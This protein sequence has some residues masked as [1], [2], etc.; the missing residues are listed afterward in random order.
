MPQPSDRRRLAD[1]RAL[2]KQGLLQDTDDDGTLLCTMSGPEAT[3][4]EGTTL[5]VRIQLPVDYPFRSPSVGFV[6]QVYH[7]NVDMSSGSICLNALNQEWTPVYN[8]S[9]IMTTLLPQLLTYPNP[10]DPLNAEAAHL[11]SEDKE[12]FERK[13]RQYQHA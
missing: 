8:L 5:Q 6:S 3:P 2:Q 7:P 11:W 12:A 13:V 1:I 10:D 9:L 4:Y